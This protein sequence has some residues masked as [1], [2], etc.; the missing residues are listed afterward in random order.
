M[1]DGFVVLPPR[2]GRPPGPV[3][4]DHRLQVRVTGDELDALTEVAHDAGQPLAAL[5]RAAVNEYVADYR[6]RLPFARP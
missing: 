5:V 4:A 2:R 3:R 6:E 1:T